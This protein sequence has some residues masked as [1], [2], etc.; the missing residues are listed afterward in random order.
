MEPTAAAKS[1]ITLL[2]RAHSQ[3]QNTAFLQSPLLAMLFCQLRTRACVLHSKIYMTSRTWLAF[4]AAVVTADMHH[5]L[6]HCVD[7]TVWSPTFSK[8]QWMSRCEFLHAEEM[9]ISHLWCGSAYETDVILLNC[10]SA[11]IYCTATKRNS[12]LIE[13]FNLYCHPTR[14]HLWH[15]G[16]I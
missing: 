3:L 8:T 9:A 14:I 11:A 13:R 15:C 6:P 12:I 2:D 7:S 10:P 16:S 5:P 1:I 4:H